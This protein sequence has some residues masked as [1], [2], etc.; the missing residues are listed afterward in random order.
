MG[1]RIHGTP[2]GD[3]FDVRLDAF[4]TMLLEGG[5]GNDTIDIQG[6]GT[7]RLVFPSSWHG[8][9]VDLGKD[10]VVDDGFGDIDTIS[11]SLTFFAVI[12]GDEA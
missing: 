5:C 2:Y 8:I 11:P 4:Q 10:V 3:V 6:S 1:F 12:H 7:L 9:Y